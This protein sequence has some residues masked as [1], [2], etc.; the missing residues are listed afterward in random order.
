MFDPSVLMSNKMALV[1][2]AERK[3]VDFSDD[4]VRSASRNSADMNLDLSNVE[5]HM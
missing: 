3:L 4:S 2:F 5:P 1:K